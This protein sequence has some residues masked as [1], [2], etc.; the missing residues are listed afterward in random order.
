MEDGMRGRVRALAFILATALAPAFHGAQAQRAEASEAG[1]KSAFIYKFAGYVEWPSGAFEAAEAPFV[2]GVAG[3]EEIAADLARIVGGRNVAGH[4]ATV[5][6]VP[7]AEALKGVHML[8]IGKSEAARQA[9]LLRAAR[10][11]GV[12]AVT[13]TERGLEQGSAINFVVS[14]DRVGFEVSLDAVEKTGHRISARML[15]VAR[16]V[17]PKS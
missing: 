14:E 10:Q 16:R 7:D 1:V 2:F 13:E 9:A 17:V 8:F 3:A 6:R 4:L 12:L 5:K 11:H 15:T